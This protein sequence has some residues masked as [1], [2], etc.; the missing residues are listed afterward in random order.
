M[1]KPE[2]KPTVWI[3]EDL[4]DMVYKFAKNEM[5]IADSSVAY[6]LIRKAIEFSCTIE[7]ENFKKFLKGS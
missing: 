6:L 7:K 2:L 3:G 5:G 1:A 4:V